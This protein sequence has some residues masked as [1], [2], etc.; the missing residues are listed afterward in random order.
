MPRS[1]RRGQL[2]LVFWAQALQ[3]FPEMWVHY[4]QAHRLTLGRSA[5]TTAQDETLQMFCRIGYTP[6]PV[7][8]TPRRPL[9]AF[10]RA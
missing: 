2:R 6:V 7:P 8:G 1:R 4:E 9:Q 3:E 10:L 5:P